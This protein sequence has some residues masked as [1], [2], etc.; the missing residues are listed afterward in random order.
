[1]QLKDIFSKSI[2][3]DINGVIKADQTDD[4][5]KWIELDEYVITKEVDGHLRNFFSRYAEAVNANDPSVANNVGVWITGFFGSGKSHFIKILSYLLE[6]KEIV[7]D[8]ERKKPVDF[9]A[10]KV[11][12]ALFF[13][14]IKK[15]VDANTDVILFNIDSK[16]QQ[17]KNNDAILSVFQNV[18]NE[19]LGYS[20]DY[21]YIAE[22]ERFLDNSGKYAEFKKECLAEGFDW[23]AEKGKVN[24]KLGIFKRALS[25]VLNQSEEDC[26]RLIDEYKNSPNLTVEGFAEK[27]KEYLDKC[28]KTKRIIFLIDEIGQFIG[29]DTKLMLNL[30]TITENLGTICKGRAWIVV[31]SQQDVDA[32][33]G[34]FVGSKVN[35]FSKIQGRFNIRMALSSA[36]TDEVIRKRL[37]DKKDAFKPILKTIYDTKGDIIKSQTTFTDL[38]KTYR[39]FKTSDEFMESYPFLPYQFDLIQRVFESIRKVGA[40]GMHLSRGE[41]S[42]LDSFQNALKTIAD[43]DCESLVPL[44]EFYPSIKS[45]LDTAVISTIEKAHENPSLT[46][47]DQNLLKTLFLIRYVDEM[48]GTISNLVILSINKID[49]DKVAL[50]KQIQESLNRLEQQNLI[51]HSGNNYYFLTNDEQNIAREI[52]N[53]RLD[54]TMAIK[55]VGS[56]IAD[57]IMSSKRAYRYKKNGK[58]FNFSIMSDGQFIRYTGTE[59]LCL[60]FITPQNDLYTSYS[61][62]KCVMES[63]QSGVLVIK[64]A[65]D[66]KI[67]ADVITY[68]KTNAYLTSHHDSDTIPAVKAIFER[69]S[70]ENRE[71]AQ[72]IKDR[73]KA[74]ILNANFYAGGRAITLTGSQP[75]ELLEKGLETLIDVSYEKL[76]LLKDL[77]SEPLKE[78]KSLLLSSDDTTSLGLKECD[79]NK[80][81]MDEVRRHITL[82]NNR[83]TQI[84]LKDVIDKFGSRPYGWPDNET[85]IILTRMHVMEEI[86]FVSNGDI[87]TRNQIYDILSS[88]PRRWNSVTINCRQHVDAGAL[89]NARKLAQ[90]VNGEIG[91]DSED[92][93]FKNMKKALKDKIDKL[94]G[95]KAK[96][97]AR[98]SYPGEEFI[99]KFSPVLLHLSKIEDSADFINKMLNHSAELEDFAD[100]FEDLE[101]FYT[102]QIGNWNILEAKRTEFEE[103]RYFLNKTDAKPLLIRLDE[104]FDAPA[105]YN[106]IAEARDIADKVSAIQEKELNDYRQSAI[107][108]IDETITIVS[109]ALS[110]VNDADLSNSCLMPLQSL[111]KAVETEKSISKLD[112]Q[113]QKRAN[114]CLDNANAKIE[115]KLKEQG[116]PQETIPQQ[117]SVEVKKYL[118]KPYLRTKEDVEEFLKVLEKDLKE[119]IDNNQYVQIV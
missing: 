43:Y 33:I 103:N 27:V 101:N 44:Y 34:D 61:E 77:S 68:L 17:Q 81:A 87:L 79:V 39:Q 13:G 104:I 70:A 22:I 28:G 74:M 83:S 51:N 113:Y 20:R 117:K 98:P 19:K 14:D 72:I 30:Q 71:R 108:A 73:I 84:V 92:E 31:T 2:N 11:N 110:K 24:F 18:F 111:K 96:I 119:A 1:M 35:D 21:P 5:S 85:G 100:G 67:I 60:S 63:S 42:M 89:A 97:E 59:E 36:N 3:R 54:L 65:D 82:Q 47:F 53:E 78:I 109:E 76:N 115:Q 75:M 93:F 88:G 37:L 80:S 6:N 69:L 16:A 38:T 62:G 29:Q 26:A 23:D 114:D 41:R 118:K 48:K 99:N 8:S 52:K 7:K 49:T 32:I 66:D 15:S 50:T 40:A 91:P 102:N 9:F 12:D 116:K 86:N 57:E 90:K 56:V 10:N 106:L 4:K 107:K 94:N 112:S 105:P 46:P 25:K 45:F 95:Y 58:D 64:C 55:Y